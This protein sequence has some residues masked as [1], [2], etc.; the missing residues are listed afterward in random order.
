MSSRITAT[1][2][3]EKNENVL[4][5][6]SMLSARGQRTKPK[7]TREL[8]MHACALRN[9]APA[10]QG[11]FSKYYASEKLLPA[12]NNKCLENM[13]R[14]NNPNSSDAVGYIHI[15]SWISRTHDFI[16]YIITFNSNRH[17]AL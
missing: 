8:R 3:V 4:C 2:C 13:T 14:A 1:A 15:Y 11:L 6:Q 16:Y 12:I 17:Y 5:K 10:T 9:G 7:L